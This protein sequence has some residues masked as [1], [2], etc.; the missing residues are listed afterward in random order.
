MNFS[1]SLTI[2]IAG[3]NDEHSPRVGL[4]GSSVRGLVQAVGPGH[5]PIHVRSRRREE[6][7]AHRRR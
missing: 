5:G 6:Q 2:Q 4:D 3:F 1:R 7:R